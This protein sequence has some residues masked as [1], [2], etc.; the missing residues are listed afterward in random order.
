MG[1]VN[2]PSPYV[3]MSDQAGQPKELHHRKRLLKIDRKLGSKMEMKRE[4]SRTSPP[5]EEVIDDDDDDEVEVMDCE[6]ASEINALPK[7][8]PSE[9]TEKPQTVVSTEPSKSPSGSSSEKPRS[10]VKRSDTEEEK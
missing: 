10:E 2:E 7:T 9:S 8:E 4:Q 3:V 6:A 1:D 5:P